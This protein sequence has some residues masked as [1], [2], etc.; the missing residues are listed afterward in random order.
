MRVP[1]VFD[2]PNNSGRPNI[3]V[4]FTSIYFLDYSVPL[5]FKRGA[6]DAMFLRRMEDKGAV[7]LLEED[8][9]SCNT[10]S[11]DCRRG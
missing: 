8:D 9:E 10:F 4:W 2:N 7:L 3:T 1:M 6:A 11:K 5:L